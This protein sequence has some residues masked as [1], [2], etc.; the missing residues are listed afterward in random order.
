MKIKSREKESKLLVMIS[1]FFFSLIFFLGDFISN[2]SSSIIFKGEV[3][4]IRKNLGDIALHLLASWWLKKAVN[5]DGNWQDIPHIGAGQLERPLKYYNFSILERSFVAI[6]DYFLNNLLLSHNLTLLL[7]FLLTYLSTFLLAKRI[8]KCFLAAILAALTFSFSYIR[9]V[10]L[11]EN[12]PNLL[13]TF[14][15]P[16]L[17]YAFLSFSE[18]RKTKYLVAFGTLFALQIIADFQVAYFFSLFIFSFIF[19]YSVFKREPSLFFASLLVSLLFLSLAFPVLANFLL[20]TKKHFLKGLPYPLLNID[21]W[22]IFLKYAGKYIPNR[23]YIPPLLVLLSP[24]SLFHEKKWLSLSFLFSFLLFWFFST[25]IKWEILRLILPF[26]NWGMRVPARFI[27]VS[28]FS[29]SLCFVLSFNVLKK[30]TKNNPKINFLLFLIL[31]SLLLM[32]MELE[33]IHSF[34]LLSILRKE[35]KVYETIANDSSSFSILEIP[36][37]G[38]IGGYYFMLMMF[39]HSKPLLNAYPNAWFAFLEE[40][41]YS[42]S[43][44]R[45]LPPSSIMEEKTFEEALT[46]LK[47]ANVKFVILHRE[48][49]K[50]EEL[51]RAV[52]LLAKMNYSIYRDFGTSILLTHY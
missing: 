46:L 20:L 12:H 47:R 8:S 4:D 14:L 41:Y 37:D 30:L 23:Y 11:T 17:L 13:L 49:M 31:F 22:N 24:L 32:Q 27:M 43:N 48:F 40:V 19:I 39:I 10:A 34:P 2:I 36:N 33:C 5:Y 28:N 18:E 44:I 15:S 6:I 16:L 1:V 51:K 21:N 52:E 29:L 38:D 50:E 26:Y 45:A 35:G 9:I 25:G 42:K 7:T 3:E